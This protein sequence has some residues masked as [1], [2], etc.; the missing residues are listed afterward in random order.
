MQ[1]FRLPFV[2]MVASKLDIYGGVAILH[3]FITVT[4]EM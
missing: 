1:S 2:P 3:D 4:V